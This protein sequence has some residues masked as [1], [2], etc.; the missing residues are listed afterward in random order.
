[1]VLRQARTHTSYT[2]HKVDYP[3]T[4]IVLIADVPHDHYHCWKKS[5]CRR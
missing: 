3:L 1:M 4:S 5:E 2:W